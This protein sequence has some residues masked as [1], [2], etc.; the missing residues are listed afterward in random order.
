MLSED[1]T[2]EELKEALDYDPDTGVFTWK[3]TYRNVIPAGTVAGCLSHAGYTQIRIKRVAF[4]AHRL[5]WLWMTGAW[6]PA[7]IDHRNGDKLDNRWSNLRLSDS[8]ANALNI[9]TPRRH[10]STGILGVRQCR[11]GRFQAMLRAYRKTVYLGTYD[12]PEEASEAYASA[13]AFVMDA[14]GVL[15]NS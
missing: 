3:A 15:P 9:S 4:L 10:N 8:V 12:T 11:P 1:L 13:K 2:Q 7:I 6:P 14:A 5:A